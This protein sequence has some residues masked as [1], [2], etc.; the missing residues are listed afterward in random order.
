[1][2]FVNKNDKQLY[3]N[4]VKGII[5]ELND[6]D[7]YCS[8]TLK[9]GHENTRLVNFT[10]KK[11]H[12]DELSRVKKIGDKVTIRFFLSSR[13]KNERWYTVANVLDVSDD[14]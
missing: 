1:M 10:L 5:E 14:F 13:F 3:F 7:I 2:E 6:G 9:V 11:P 4:Q 12:F 8:I